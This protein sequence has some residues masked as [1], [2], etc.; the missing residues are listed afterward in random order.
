MSDDAQVLKP[1]LA[2]LAAGERLSVEDAQAAFDGI[3]T[4]HATAAQ[5]GAFLMALHLRGE[6]VDEI[7]GGALALR[8]HMERIEAPQGALDTCGTGGDGKGTFNISTAA[9]LVAAGA[10]AT[11][12]KHGNRAQSSKSGSADV[13]QALGVNLDAPRALVER[14]LKEAHI[15]FLFAPRHHQAMRY[16]AEARR[17]LGFRTIFNLLGP[18]ANPAGATHQLIGVFDEAWLEPM[19]EV[20]K[21]LGSIRVWVVHGRD[22]L[23][24]LTTTGPS[25]VAALEDGKIR[26]F[27]LTPEDV[28]L[29]RA[30][31]A[32]LLGGSAQENARRLS[33]LLEGERGPIRDVVVLN[34][35]AALVVAGLAQDLAEGVKR[36]AQALD[37]GKAKAALDALVRISN[38]RA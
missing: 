24:E 38:G 6:T 30:K 31:P 14:A 27:A 21:T 22:G 25:E 28:G 1:V 9:A 2:R 17:E 36:A 34:A 19:A 8:A 16:V 7:V 11:V 32:E 33:A 35:A 18:L 13:L 3:M 37:E 10:G 4:G 15:A 29:A 26:R 12:A 5:I 20:L 23:D